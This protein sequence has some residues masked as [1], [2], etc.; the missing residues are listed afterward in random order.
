LSQLVTALFMQTDRKA[1]FTHQK[2]ILR[3]DVCSD[4]TR[5]H[6]S[7]CTSNGKMLYWTSLV[8]TACAECPSRFPLRQDKWRGQ[9]ILAR[10]LSSIKAQ[11]VDYRYVYGP[12]A[13]NSF[14]SKTVSAVGAVPK[15]TEQNEQQFWIARYDKTCR[16]KLS[17]HTSNDKESTAPIIFLAKI[18]FSP[19]AVLALS[20]FIKNYT[21]ILSLTGSHIVLNN[22]LWQIW[23]IFINYSLKMKHFIQ[24]ITILS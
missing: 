11:R 5:T 13:I 23:F 9:Y 12:P 10:G 17:I 24:A 18:K 7:Y 8:R 14:G 15:V 3:G 1:V 19:Q 16:K 4:V 21:N 6:C 22:F 20:S 2:K